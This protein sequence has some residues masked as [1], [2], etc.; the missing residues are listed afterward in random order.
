MSQ[1]VVMHRQRRIILASA[2]SVLLAT[3]GW[4]SGFIP[5]AAA[6]DNGI[7]RAQMS[8]SMVEDPDTLDPT[9]GQT[10][11]GRQVFANLCEKLYDINAS[12]HV[13]PQL[14]TKLP[15]LSTD[16]LTAT[17]S[18][19]RRAVFNDGTPFNAAA[20]KMTLDRDRENP[21]SARKGELASVKKVTVKDEH[22]IVLTLS[23]PYVPLA[24]VLADRA[25]MILSPTAL[26]KLG[27]HFGDSPVCVGPFSFVE[28]VV[29]DRVVLEKSAMYYDAAQ[30]HIK[31]LIMRPIPDSAVRVAN[32]RSG[33]LDIIDRI[34]TPD[35]AQLLNDDKVKTMNVASLG[36][37]SIELNTSTGPFKDKRVRQAF[38]LAI[39]RD[40][41]NKTVYGGLYTATCQPFSKKN[42]YFFKD[43]KCPTRNVKAA[44]ALLKQAGLKLPVTVELLGTNATLSTQ[45]M[46]L[47]QS[48]AAEAGFKV[49]VQSLEVGTLMSNF[50]S[51]NFDAAILMWSGR[52]D[53]DGNI[54]VFQATNGSQNFGKFSSPQVDALLQEANSTPDIR[55]RAG[56]YRQ[57]W[58]LAMANNN[59]IV[60]AIPA[61]LVGYQK[62]VQ[63]LKVYGDG[64]IRLKGVS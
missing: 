26:K 16:G 8:V 32:F 50:A 61:I 41:I 33:A 21:R 37:D 42:P 38:A 56:L 46:E 7:S 58:D 22:T 44:Q 6:A 24:A 13:I 5:I 2:L 52:V 54:S 23:A 30:V 15:V 45:R 62:D 31:R 47:I 53:P 43:L 12:N 1:N 36:H 51:G 40:Q 35:Y 18:L 25:G 10:L 48:Q 27:D 17:I 59:E 55:K 19:R 28:R 34:P 3:S 57:I 29:G 14:A 60:L 9:F 11:G 39:D 64:L 49:D 20:V 4:S 63:G